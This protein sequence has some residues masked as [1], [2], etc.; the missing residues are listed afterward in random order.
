MIISK[1]CKLDLLQISVKMHRHKIE[2]G[3]VLNKEVAEE[4]EKKMK[5][6]RYRP[7]KNEKKTIEKYLVTLKKQKQR[8]YLKPYQI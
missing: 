7:I 1:I 3:L 8:K 4:S 5:K 2:I 6:T